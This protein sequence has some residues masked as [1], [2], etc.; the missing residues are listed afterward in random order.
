MEK[1]VPAPG[2]SHLE[3][4]D[5]WRAF[6]IFGT[7]AEH[8][9]PATAAFQ[10]LAPQ[11]GVVL[12]F[13]LSGFLITGSLL[14]A[15]HAPGPLSK[16]AITAEFYRRRLLRILPPY[17]LLLLAC[18]LMGVPF[19][20]GSA[21]GSAFFYLNFFAS[22]TADPLLY[23]GHIWTLCIE[24]QFYLV[25]PLVMLWVPHRHLFRTCMGIIVGATL[26]RMILATG[27]VTGLT[28]RNLP[29]VQADALVGGALLALLQDRAMPHPWRDRWSRWMPGLALLGFA[30]F[31]LPLL[32]A[33]PGA[34][35]L[36]T[37]TG[38][39]M[40]MIALIG[41]TVSR[42]VSPLVRLLS[43]PPL[44]YLGRISYGI[45]LFH[46]LAYFPFYFLQKRLHHPQWMSQTWGFAL[47]CS[48]I[49]ILLAS[50]SWFCLEKPLLKRRA[51]SRQLPAPLA[52]S[53][54]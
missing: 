24:M 30:L 17:Y 42:P 22:F 14:K 12:F 4:L 39:T 7:L 40:A 19:T 43:L 2:T 21:S 13:V 28:I 27:G 25:W 10:W 3:A 36:L 18:W 11:M 33:W 47:C 20:A 23:L 1:P 29:F 45:Y 48:A 16:G 37:P 38:R 50:L 8:Y 44:T 15:R 32:P 46:F 54:T 5:G 49:T 31:Y 9:L 51:P 41:L 53:A 26:L 35:G 34:L 6:A 52:A